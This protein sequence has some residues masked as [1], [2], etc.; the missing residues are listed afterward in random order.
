MGWR[1]WAESW[2][3]MGSYVHP[4][5]PLSGGGPGAF[6]QPGPLGIDRGP[7]SRMPQP[8]S[9]A[10]RHFDWHRLPAIDQAERVATVYASVQRATRYIP[11]AV[12]LATG[13][14][15]HA[16]IAGVVPGLALAL[17]V[18]ALTTLSGALV[19]AALGAFAGGAGAVPGAALGGTWGSEAG[20]VILEWLGLGFPA[21]SLRHMAGAELAAPDHQ[22]QVAAAASL[23]KPSSGGASRGA[24]S[25]SAAEAQPSRAAPRE[26]TPAAGTSLQPRQDPASPEQRQGLHSTPVRQRRDS[27]RLRQRRLRGQGCRQPVLAGPS[28]GSM[29]CNRSSSAMACGTGRGS[30]TTSRCPASTGLTASCKSQ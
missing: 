6:R 19:G 1:D 16:V 14:E 7:S 12:A 17:G 8:Q 22:P 23:R 3:A 13:E 11:R 10:A 29:T 25:P 27:V 20:L 15:L 9:P 5:A 18:T 24:W 30:R 2:G 26:A 4:G 21:A 28:A